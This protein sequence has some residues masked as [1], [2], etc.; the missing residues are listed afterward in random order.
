[1]RKLSYISTLAIVISLISCID[2]FSPPEVYNNDSFL[3][4]DGY[5]EAG[6]KDTSWV[7]LSRSL[8]LKDPN[9]P[10]RETGAAIEL[11]NEAGETYT[12]G[13]DSRRSGSYFLPPEILRL[14]VPYRITIRLTNGKVYQSSWEMFRAS[15]PIDS[16]TYTREGREGIW[17]YVNSHDPG[18]QSR[19]YKWSFSET[20]EYV[21]PLYSELEMVNGAL[22]Y[23][24]QEINRCWKTE[25]PTRISVFTTA[26]LSQDV[27][28]AFPVHYVAAET[29]RLLLA[30]HIRINQQVL[31]REGYEYWSELAR[32]NETNGSI[33]DPFPSQLTGNLT[34]LDDPKE[35]VLGF[36]G[37][38][39]TQSSSRFIYAGLGRLHE[40]VLQDTLSLME[41][42]ESNLTIVKKIEP[43]PDQFH[44][45]LPECIDCRL[46][47]GGT[48]VKPDFW[49]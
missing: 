4:Y 19:F 7:N 23:R 24:T 38:G 47:G 10:P 3:V 41:L 11:E 45:A 39:V 18:N 40:C 43:T 49:P 17:I 48:I 33:F 21:T 35:K 44:V 25:A 32:N 31:T 26:S 12:F 8:S 30:Y 27:V 5:I 29:N 14:D 20:W 46:W 9:V 42:A 22:V 16:I 2:S 34:S 15:P 1:M 37:G 6:G 36:F 28:R 13:E